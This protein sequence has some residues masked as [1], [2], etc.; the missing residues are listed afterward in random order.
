MRFRLSSLAIVITAVWLLV[1]VGC[2]VSFTKVSFGDF[3]VRVAK[4]ENFKTTV[5][6]NASLTG[7]TADATYE[8]IIFVGDVLLA[9]N[10]EF[11]MRQHTIDYPYEGLDFLTLANNPAIVGNFEASI[12][13]E[14]NPTPIKQITFSVDE[15]LAG[16]LRSNGF[17]HVSLA[18]NH[19][20]DFGK[21]GLLHTRNVLGK[22]LVTFGDPKEINTQSSSVVQINDVRVGLLGINALEEVDSMSLKNKLQELSKLSEFQIIYIHWGEEYALR[23]NQQ[24]RNLAE[25]LVLYGADLIIGHHPHVV[26]GVDLIDGVPVFYS[27]GNYIFDQYFSQD[28]KEG[29]VLALD[30]SNSILISL[31]PVTSEVTLSQPTLMSPDKHADFLEKLARRSHPD[32]QDAVSRGLVTIDTGIATSDKVAIIQNQRTYVE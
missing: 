7:D 13:K 4:S 6:H 16:T 24:Q 8:S 30:F 2:T 22:D 18:N 32:L 14:H 15:R 10:V 23:H 12:P 21:E 20:Y 9:R 29:L 25:D 31:I 1:G 28:V 3:G 19:S 17:T 27:L 11:L 26:Q 5:F